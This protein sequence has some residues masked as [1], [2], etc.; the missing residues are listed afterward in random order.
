MTTAVEEYHS[1]LFR[2]IAARNQ[3]RGEARAVLTVLEA[4]GV[5][6][7]TEVGEQILACTDLTQ[8]DAWLRRAGTATSAEDVIQEDTQSS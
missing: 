2:E 5:P 7:P 8:L 3:A 1:E 6:V 4:R